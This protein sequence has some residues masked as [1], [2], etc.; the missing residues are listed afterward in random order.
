MIPLDTSALMAAR[1]RLRSGQ[2]VAIPTETVYGLAAS[3]DSEVGLKAIFALKERP[4][5]DPL[6]VHVNSIKQAQSLTTGWSPL[7][8]FI[9]RWFWPGPLTV[10][11]PKSAH[12]NPIITSGLETVAIRWPSHPLAQDLI[13]LVGTP[14][15]APSANKFGRT[16]PS[17]AD[18]VREE[19]S[20]SD[21]QILDG[22]PSAVGVESTVISFSQNSSGEEIR[23]LR[24]GGVTEEALKGALERWSQPVSVVRAESQESPGHLKHHYMPKV[25]LAILLKPPET[26]DLLTIAIAIG[27]RAPKNARELH[28]A[29]DAT[30]AARILYSEMRELCDEGADFLWVLATPEREGGLWTAIWDRLNRAASWNRGASNL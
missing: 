25:P 30:Q 26:K 14:L 11:L 12:V 21:L 19:F 15:A 1:D 9:A 4:F 7:A 28:L 22:G 24:P 20:G 3:I 6:I 8:D 23:I 29:D 16:S 18:H 2:V 17:T 27:S 5:F 10:V 13:G